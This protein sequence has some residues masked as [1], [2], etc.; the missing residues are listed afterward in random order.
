MAKKV[1]KTGK[2]KV[3]KRKS[4]MF[5]NIKEPAPVP[6]SGRSSSLYET[7][8]PTGASSPFGITGD[9]LDN[10]LE[11]NRMQAELQ[12]LRF[13]N[14]NLSQ[15]VRSLGADV[16]ANSDEL[17]R[18]QKANKKLKKTSKM[19][20]K[21]IHHFENTDERQLIVKYQ[22]TIQ[23]QETDLEKLQKKYQTAAKRLREIDAA[24]EL[25]D[26]TEDEFQCPDWLEEY[27]TIPRYPVGRA[28]HVPRNNFIQ[29]MQEDLR[30]WQKK[31]TQHHFY[32]VAGIGKTHFLLSIARDAS[33][34]RIFT[35][36]IF[37]NP[38]VPLSV[39]AE[40]SKPVTKENNTPTK[41]PV[42][43]NGKHRKG[44]KRKRKKHTYNGEAAHSGKEEPSFG[45]PDDST[46]LRGNCNIV[47][48]SKFLA[49]VL[50]KQSALE[51][52]LIIWDANDISIEQLQA[53]QSFEW[54]SQ[55]L[56]L[57][58]ASSP[59]DLSKCNYKIYPLANITK[60]S[61]ESLLTAYLDSA[62]VTEV[63]EK[64][65]ME[66][67]KACTYNPYLLAIAGSNLNLQIQALPSKNA[68]AINKLFETSIEL[69]Q[70][71]SKE[72]LQE[73]IAN[74]EYDYTT[75][76]LYNALLKCAIFPRRVLIPIG[77]FALLLNTSIPIAM[78]IS[79]L[80]A[81]RALIHFENESINLQQPLLVALQKIVQEDKRITIESLSRQF[82]V[83]I[84]KCCMPSH[85]KPNRPENAKREHDEEERLEHVVWSSFQH[86]FNGYEPDHPVIVNTYRYIFRYLNHHLTQA[87]EVDI[88]KGLLQSEKWFKEMISHF[89]ENWQQFVQQE[90]ILQE[91]AL[92]RLGLSLLHDFDHKVPHSHPSLV[93]SNAFGKFFTSQHTIDFIADDVVETT[94]NTIMAYKLGKVAELDRLC[95]YDEDIEVYPEK[96]T[97]TWCDDRFI[98]TK[99]NIT[100]MCSMQHGLYLLFATQNG[101]VYQV[102]LQRKSKKLVRSID[103]SISK[104]AAYKD[105]RYVTGHVDGSVRVFSFKDAGE[106]EVFHSH[107]S[108]IT[109]LVITKDGRYILSASEDPDC[110]VRMYDIQMG[111]EMKYFKGSNAPITSL[112]IDSQDRFFYSASYDGSIRMFLIG[113]N[114]KKNVERADGKWFAEGVD[115]GCTSLSLLKSGRYCV[116]GY[117]DTIVRLFDMTT[118]KVID[119][120]T[121]H[122]NIIRAV[123]LSS[124]KQ[125]CVSSDWSGLI[126]ISEIQN[127]DGAA[128][129][130]TKEEIPHFQQLQVFAIQDGCVPSWCTCKNKLYFTIGERYRAD[131]TT[132]EL[133]AKPILASRSGEVDVINVALVIGNGNYTS[134]SVTSCPHAVKDATDMNDLITETLNFPEDN[135]IFAS[136]VTMTDLMQ[137]VANY[138]KLILN[139]RNTNPSAHILSLVYYSGQV[140]SGQY[141]PKNSKD[142]F[143]L[144]TDFKVPFPE[145]MDDDI[146]L[147]TEMNKRA[148]N[149][150]EILHLPADYHVV[151]V[152]GV[153][154]VNQTLN[155]IHLPELREYL[156]CT[157]DVS[158][159]EANNSLLTSFILEGW[160]E[161]PEHKIG[162]I[163]NAVENEMIY[164]EEIEDLS[165][166][167]VR[168]NGSRL[169]DM[170]VGDISKF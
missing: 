24:N 160:N 78:S 79:Q 105:E 23:K 132:L 76:T 117:E 14:Q 3:S 55:T 88:G 92:I 42:H 19:Q 98:P 37:Y 63:F 168:C 136:D 56:I 159:I 36:G 156:L 53:I 52:A 148:V 142:N 115:D 43:S 85:T 133:T 118:K 40:A 12:K 20:A 33:V 96:E 2:R 123:E 15:K 46:L 129:C 87:G 69:W 164:D 107:Q 124:N 58:S 94:G 134:A 106:Q 111:L 28:R 25:L 65:E 119:W 128:Y 31:E 13:E 138:E 61:S 165:R 74:F 162:D 81:D 60:M 71:P 163:F 112:M 70:K 135:V 44:K 158:R 116:A 21:R 11:F 6:Q 9:N 93:L 89:P 101:C 73:L 38:W 48:S 68:E 130:G 45:D 146:L 66:L 26:T 109:A 169:S 143:L 22:G 140:E 64:Q 29:M 167:I 147:R 145:V 51:R 125:Y 99:F 49:N 151:V 82:L 90:L 59:A 104:I 62:H 166:S 120:Y 39:V 30:S 27:T 72:A 131:T 154:R 32:G 161:K 149:L 137:L 57:V 8:T 17:K 77:I 122:N 35:T 41:A 34:K 7:P 86:P 110:L 83:V 157:S 121:R 95:G 114:Y 84:K 16:I 155:P 108:I 91:P 139:L 4:G 153:K 54:G 75:L 50:S 152:D 127:Q 1:K 5:P 102:S 170:V 18:V 113:Q 141:L 80:L 126:V 150:Y 67:C 103:V 100:A 10:D 144:P 97:G 47:N